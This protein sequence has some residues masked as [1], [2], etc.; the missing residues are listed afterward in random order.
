M[1]EVSKKYQCR[2]GHSEAR[3][4]ATFHYTDDDPWAVRALFEGYGEA[5]WWIFSREL[6]VTGVYEYVDPYG[7][8]DV[9]VWCPVTRMHR[10][11][12][13]YDASSGVVCLRVSNGVDALT[14]RVKRD[15]V[16]EFLDET[17]HLVEEGEETC[18]MNWDSIVS[19]ILGS[20]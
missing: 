9:T 15:K 10:D 5:E 20:A 2:A 6:L 14:F 17:Y 8:G 13:T 3:V 16:I 4:T 11:G 18:F 19:E 12:L 1:A 7:A